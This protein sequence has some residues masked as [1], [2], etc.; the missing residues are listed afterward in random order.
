MIVPI[1]PT[2][3]CPDRDPR[4]LGGLAALVEAAERPLPLEEVHVRTTIVGGFAH[5]VVAQRFH[6]PLA[7][8]LE[9]VYR[10]PLPPDGAV[11]DLE[12]RCGE[13]TVRADLREKQA[14]TAAFE[15]ARAAGHRAALVTAERADV[16][17]VRVT[18]LPP[19]EAVTVRLVLVEALESVDGAWR[20]RFPTT[21]A[22]RYLP[23]QPTGHADGAAQPDTDRVPDASRLQPPLRLDGGTRLDLEVEVRGPVAGVESSLHAVRVG[24]GAECLRVAPSGKATLDADFILAITP[25]AS[26][27]WTTRA[28]TDGAFTAVQVA[29][30]LAPPAALPRDAVFL[31]DISGSMGGTKLVA[32]KAAL[33]TALHGLVQG[34]RFKLIA[35][36]DRLER[37]RGG[38][39]VPYDDRALADADRWVHKLAARGGTEMLP[40]LQAGLEGEAEP[41][42]LRTVLFI[43]DG[44]AWNEQEL[45]AAV[46]N[47]RGA[48]RLFTLGIDTAVNASLL[49]R[50]ARVGGGTCD[51]A[52]PDDDIEAVVAR[53]E[54]RFGSPLVTDLRPA[55]GATRAAGLQP[56]DVFAGRPGL[57]LI[58]GAGPVRL[59]AGAPSG[60]VVEA[61]PE[62]VSFP[63]GA[64]WGR[65]RIA[66]LEDRL[67]LRPFEEEA[68]RPEILRVSLERRVLSRFSA[69]IAVERSRVVEGELVHVEQ[70]AEAPRAW[71]MMGAGAG[72]PGGAAPMMAGAVPLGPPP[73]ARPAPAPKASMAPPPPSARSARSIVSAVVDRLAPSRKRAAADD[74]DA[75]AAPSAPLEAE[76]VLGLADSPVAPA[77]GAGALARAQGADGSIGDA[78][79]T[80]AALVVL[81]LGGHTRT[82]GLR[83][84]TV[85]KAVAWLIT[86]GGALGASAIRILEAVESGAA[87]PNDA[88]EQ[89]AVA[90]AG[91]HAGGLL[92]STLGQR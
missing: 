32:A 17:V 23:G 92:R 36:D 44:Q 80:A 60:F 82:R 37:F 34:D 78:A 42:R 87:P 4:G 53:L 67:V 64:L 63:V 73:A 48:A 77:D 56:I 28:W 38:A 68:L 3:P 74:I 43:T 86:H 66:A 90:A 26:D 55:E 2:L 49:Q 85:Q 59:V 88:I 52:T 41:G 16:H 12:L 83:K 91:S 25:G 46:A 13:V 14:A 19:G 5:T 24:V 6:N 18:R 72:A 8:P 81:A 15:A 30:P 22:P 27:A 51:L 29:P 70:P 9:A 7:S 58:E 35:F 71:D 75:F 31:V 21:I 84:R 47:R 39:F 1:P 61:T 40:A 20:W 33:T 69:L 62:A 79:S 76:A 45:T 54:A 11:I 65:Q 57:V 89:I 50:L 10:F